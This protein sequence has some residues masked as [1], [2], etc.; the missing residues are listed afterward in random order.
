MSPIK[1]IDAQRRGRKLKQ[2]NEL[3]E[4][5]SL[6][7]HALWNR[8]GQVTFAIAIGTANAL[9]ERSNDESMRSIQVGKNWAQSLFRRMGF[10][11][12]A[13]TGKVIIPEGARRESELTF[14]HDI[15][16]KVEE[17]NIPPSL[18]FNLDQTPSKHIQSSCY[19]PWRKR[20]PNLSQFVAHQINDQSQQ[21]SSKL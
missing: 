19:T 5:V 7:L 9:I 18:V 15:V 21:P 3:D 8:G 6:F 17:H 4:K 20:A 16:Q 11:K 2:G 13:T 1:G 10:K 12:A 14:L